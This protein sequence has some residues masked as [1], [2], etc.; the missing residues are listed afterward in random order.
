MVL[1]VYTSRIQHNIYTYTGKP[2]T[3]TVI[4]AK[5]HDD[6][7]LVKEIQQNDDGR[8]STEVDSAVVSPVIKYLPDDGPCTAETCRKLKDTCKYTD[9]LECFNHF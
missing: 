2:G 6:S 9:I 1:T 7:I 5:E 8:E 3:K 4:A